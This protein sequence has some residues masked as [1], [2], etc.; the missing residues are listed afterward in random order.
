MGFFERYPLLHTF[1]GTARWKSLFSA[2]REQSS[3]RQ[4]PE[5]GTLAVFSAGLI[6]L[7]PVLLTYIDAQDPEKSSMLPTIAFGACTVLA[8]VLRWRLG[9][10]F[11]TTGSW[12]QALSL[13]H[14][15]VA[16]GCIP[17]VILLIASP[18]MLA[19][20]HDI[21]SQSVGTAEPREV[22]ML[23]FLKTAGLVAFIAAWV[24]VIEEVLFRSLIVGVFRRWRLIASHRKRD[25]FAAISSSL[26]FGVAHYATWG[27]VAALALTG[28]GLGFVMAYIANGERLMPLVLYHF[29]FDVLSIS[30][31]MG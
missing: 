15:A 2:L 11:R 31:S 14:T 30:I 12:K 9:L 3:H 21:I 8:I 20:R 7:V 5:V 18:Q 23:V 13:T 22:G 1:L 4:E 17:A 25:I 16:L 19:D 28:L 10:P 26:I 29:I 27:P 24:A 6:A